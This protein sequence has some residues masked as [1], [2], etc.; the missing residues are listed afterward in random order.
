MLNDVIKSLRKRRG[1]TQSELAEH[2]NLS[3]STIASWEN[4]SRRPDLD[5][6]P[7][8][9]QFFGVT[10]DDL[11]GRDEE[12]KEKPQAPQTPEAR[13]LASGIDKMPPRDRERA[14]NLVK[15]MFEQYAD[16]FDKGD[17][18]EA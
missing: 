1:L 3:Q 4:G 12:T 15:L 13:I 9:A 2:L 6:L 10:V 17:N 11:L 7:K 8:L 5:F 14:L 18:D 16:Y